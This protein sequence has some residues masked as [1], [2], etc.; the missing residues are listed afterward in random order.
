M[1]ALKGKAVMKIRL[2]WKSYNWRT[3]QEACKAKN[4]FQVCCQCSK[5]ETKLDGA[6]G[7]SKFG[8][9]MF[10]PEVFRKQMHCIEE[11]TC[12]TV[13]IFGNPRSDSAP[14]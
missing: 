1:A 3:I 13:E 9:P 2:Q 8:A 4:R 12:D 5:A 7:R 10:E 6:R 11:S 14:P